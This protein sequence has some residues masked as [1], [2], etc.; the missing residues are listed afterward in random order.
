[1]TSTEYCCVEK[2]HI[3]TQKKET[4]VGEQVQKLE[5]MPVIVKRIKRIVFFVCVITKAIYIYCR[6][7]KKYRKEK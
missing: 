1:M 7:F 6:K 4:K 5:I 2:T 3:I